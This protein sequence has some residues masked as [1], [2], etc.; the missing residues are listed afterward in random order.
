MSYDIDDDIT[1]SDDIQNGSQNA[2]HKWID[3]AETVE[4]A[5]SGVD[6]GEKDENFGDTDYI[7]EDN[8]TENSE[9][10]DVEFIEIDPEEPTKKETLP[11]KKKKKLKKWQLIV[12]IVAAVLVAALIAGGI[13]YNYLFGGATHTKLNEDDL[14]VVEQTE[15][16]EYE[17]SNIVNIAL[18]GVDLGDDWTNYGRSDAIMIMSINKKKGTVK[19]IS[20]LRDTKAEIEGYDPQKINA[21]YQN[22]GPTLA[23]KTLNSNFGLNI[24]D[25]IS[26]NFGEL[27]QLIDAM[28]GV[29]IELTQDEAD[30]INAG[31]SYDENNKFAGDFTETV[32][33]GMNHL[34]GAQ[35]LAF[36]RIRKID[37]DYYRADRQH[38]VMT[39]L[40]TKVKNMSTSEYPNFIHELMNVSETSLDF[41]D[42]L[43]LMSVASKKVELSSYTVPDAEYE[44]NLFGGL[45]ET[46]SWVWIYDLEKAGER[47]RSIIYDT[48]YEPDTS[49]DTSRWPT[50]ATENSDSSGG[51]EEYYEEQTETQTYEEI[52]VTPVEETSTAEETEVVTAEETEA[53]PVTDPPTET[54]EETEMATE[55]L[56][57]TDS[58]VDG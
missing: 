15:V 1:D 54:Q 32:T 13:F 35:A 41:T 21:A 38:K 58:A 33:E 27:T 50:T 17:S 14:G 11:K 18:F 51:G 40:L 7:S 49:V 55:S 20:V 29:D 5:D 28:G 3:D 36:A 25:F 6:A 48:P 45:D 22:G 44:A 31:G 37:S 46:G 12:I 52:D 10:D 34:S 9:F 16:S 4:N 43:S 42:I 56:D 24:K 2:P 30:Q 39:A 53:E 26:V 47:I 57:S 19:L 8:E 23:I